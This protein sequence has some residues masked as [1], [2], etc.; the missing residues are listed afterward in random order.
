M[1]SSPASWSRRLAR[2]ASSSDRCRPSSGAPA[3]VCS[4]STEG[5]ASPAQVRRDPA[6]SSRAPAC[7]T[8]HGWACPVSPRRSPRSWRRSEAR[9]SCAAPGRRSTRRGHALPTAP[10]SSRRSLAGG[11]PRSLPAPWPTRSRPSR[12]GLR[13]GSSRERTSRGP[14]PSSCAG[15]PS[16]CPAGSSRCRG[17]PAPPSAEPVLRGKTRVRPGEPRPAAAPIALRFVGG[18]VELCLGVGQCAVG[19]QVLDAALVALAGGASL[20][21]ALAASRD[22]R[23]AAIARAGDRVRLVAGG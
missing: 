9:R 15:K 2:R 3:Q 10:A 6:G 1:R 17:G 23:S 8:P 11:R 22:G 12:G 21:A 5:C 20:A 18:V 4:P 19:E 7:R 14:R 13:G 16:R